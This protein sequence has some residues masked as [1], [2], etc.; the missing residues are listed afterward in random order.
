LVLKLTVIAGQLV[1][2]LLE[3]AALLLL[4]VELRLDLVTGSALFK[5]G[6]FEALVLLVQGD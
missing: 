3:S 1:D 2:V 6:L 5:N 4:K